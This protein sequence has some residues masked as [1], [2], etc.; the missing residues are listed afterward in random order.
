MKI[1]A[2]EKVGGGVAVTRLTHGFLFAMQA[3]LDKAATLCLQRA[4]VGAPAS[5]LAE[6][7]AA[8]RPGAVIT[9]STADGQMQLNVTRESDDVVAEHAADLLATARDEDGA[10]LYRRFV[11]INEG[12]LPPREKRESWHLDGDKV[13]A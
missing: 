3:G 2:F 4:L 11:L 13:P 9:I 5:Q 1:I 8:F 7:E 10:A 12:D 6:M